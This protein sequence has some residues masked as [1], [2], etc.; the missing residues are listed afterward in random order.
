MDRKSIKPAAIACALA[1]AVW[2]SGDGIGIRASGSPVPGSPAADPAKRPRTLRVL[3]I[4]NSYTYFNNLPALLKGLA[5]SDKDWPQI[6]TEMIVWS[7]ATLQRH[8]SEGRASDSITEG[9]W[10]FVIL[11]EQSM[12]P[13]KDAPTMFQYA[14][15]LDARIRKSGAK[16]VLFS[17][18]ARQDERYNQAKVDSAYKYTASKL[19]AVLAPVGLAWTTALEQDPQLLLYTTDKS[20]PNA[21]GSYLAACVIYSTLVGRGTEGM[22]CSISGNPV[23]YFGVVSPDKAE[24]V[25]LND[26]E[27][28]L[29]QRIS[30]QT[31]KANRPKRPFEEPRMWRELND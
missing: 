12:M 7:G 5:A 28:R 23:N 8:L 9:N 13:I 26:R 4:G 25:N 1:F 20:H 10:D 30:W 22:T 16:T 31:V 6:E 24:L 3:F 17:T 11:Q 18:W 21:A 15:E 29:L 2:F 19:S 27:C 14:S